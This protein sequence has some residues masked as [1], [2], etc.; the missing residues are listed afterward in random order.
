[1][2]NAENLEAKLKYLMLTNLPKYFDIKEFNTEF[3]KDKKGLI[4]EYEVDF[5][6]D[7]LGSIDADLEEFLGSI[8]RL[9][10]QLY[11]L[12]GKFIVTPEGKLKSGEDTNINYIIQG[13]MIWDLNFEYDT[14][15]LFHISFRV[16]LS[17]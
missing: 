14:N 9:T 17:I 6:F 15:H 4:A 3:I 13:P 11:D 1:M 12:V 10:D 5:R 8:R 7:Y 2:I 16:D